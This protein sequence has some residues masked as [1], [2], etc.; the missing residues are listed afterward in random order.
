MDPKVANKILECINDGAIVKLEQAVVRI[1]SFT[2]EET[3]LAEYL[4]RYMRD[5]GID[6]EMHEVADPFGSGRK[7]KQPVGRI[8][9]SGEAPSLMFNGHMD[10]L[11]LAGTWTRKPFGGEIEGDWL[12]GRGSID[13]KGGLTGLVTAAVAIAKSGLT[14]KGDLV[15][16]PVV[17]H[18]VGDIGTRYNLANGITADIVIN[19][20]NADLA[21]VTR[22]VGLIKA[23]ITFTGRPMHFRTPGKESAA[24]PIEKLATFV[25][26]LGK[27]QC[28]IKPG[29][30]LTF[31]PDP[32]LPG[33]PQ[34]RVD[35][36][37]CQRVPDSFCTLEMQIRTVP[38]QNADTIRQDLERLIQALQASDFTLKASLQ[39]PSD[40][41]ADIPPYETPRDAQVVMTLV[42]WHEFVCGKPPV[43]GA[44][45]RLGAVGAANLFANAGIQAVQYGPGRHSLF[46][47]WPT[48][49]E[50]IYI[51][52]LIHGA[53]VMA[54]AAADICSAH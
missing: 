32:E 16:C 42:K 48:P 14:L 53:K 51:P 44:G 6:V 28:P 40:S 39:V 9:G 5:A 8:R 17:A 29:V 41:A 24:N 25:T 34:H 31:Q 36:V 11:P 45:D 12:Y 54:L 52:E 7:S 19:T 43:V 3:E 2:Y 15:L 4:A 50:R 10:H 49:D 37:Q 46:Q 35:E 13:E 30:W 1:P 26:T 47:Q 20:E 27:G 18:K 21:V 22:S 38:G 33:Y 23:K